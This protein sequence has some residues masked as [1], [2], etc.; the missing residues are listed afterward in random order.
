MS[1]PVL[2]ARNITRTF[3]GGGLFGSDR[4]VTAVQNAQLVLPADQPVVVAV[5]GESGSG[6]TTLARLLLG[7]LPPTSGSVQYGGRDLRKMDRQQRKTFRREV[8]AVFQDPFEVFNPFYKVD[9]ALSVPIGRFYPDLSRAERRER[10]E[11]G[12]RGVGLR[13]EETLGRFPHQLSGGQRQRIMVARALMLDPRVIVADEPVSM[14]DA[15]LRATI[16]ESLDRVH[17][18]R[19]ISLVYITHDLTTAYQVSRTLLVMYRGAVVE[20]GDVERV[21][22]EPKHPYTQLLVRSIPLPDPNRRWGGEQAARPAATASAP[23]DRGCVFAG[24]CPHAMDA[25]RQHQPP[26][27]QTDPDR[28]AACLL[29][30]DAQPLS[31][32][33]I[34]ALS[35]GEA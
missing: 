15:S 31:I 10:I 29:Y 11:E 5:A 18:E 2:E 19:G 4:A 34:A 20:V 21:M 6:K 3:G 13:P 12:L 17:R 30:E 14:V 32:E 25:C 9:H 23:D 7:V 35:H 33:Q 16:L 28:G 8:Q 24:R 22:R 1:T 27:L 26:L